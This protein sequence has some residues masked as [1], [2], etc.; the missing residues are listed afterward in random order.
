MYGTIRHYGSDV[1]Y[2]EVF[3]DPL[4]VLNSQKAITELL[5][6]RARNYSD[7][8]AMY[9]GDELSG[10]H[11]DTSHMKYSDWWRMH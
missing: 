6:K 2:T 4:V 10:L 5:E 11:W 8:P 9:M 7:R 3:G 1:I